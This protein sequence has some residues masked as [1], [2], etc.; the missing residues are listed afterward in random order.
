MKKIIIILF[1]GLILT[2]CNST[3]NMESK[4]ITSANNSLLPVGSVVATKQSGTLIITGVA[5]IDKTNHLYDY[6]GCT[7]PQGCVGDNA[8]LFNR[9]DITDVKF[10]GYNT[11]KTQQYLEEAEKDMKEILG[12]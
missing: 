7:F 4:K 2:G 9:T 11:E 10:E 3:A 6:I 5:Q 12:E 1:T 8:Y